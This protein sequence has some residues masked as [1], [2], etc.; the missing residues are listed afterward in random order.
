MPF[1]R[2][3]LT[4]LIQQTAADIAS[5]VPGADAL[6]RFSNLGI[7]A[8]MFSGLAYLHYGYQDWIAKEAVPFTATDEF[9]EGWAAPSTFLT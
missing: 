5:A 6:L 7:V 2:P 4:Q 8:K 3:T 9:L 1:S